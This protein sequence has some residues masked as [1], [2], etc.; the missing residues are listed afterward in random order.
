MK[1]VLAFPA[2][3]RHLADHSTGLLPLG[4]LSMASGLS[5]Q[6][7]EVTVVHL[8]QYR[9]KDAVRIIMDGAPD[10]VGLSCFTF[11]RHE[12]FRIAAA[13]RETGGGKKPFIVLG[14]PHASP[15]APELLV[16]VSAVDA[17]AVGEGERTVVELAERLQSGKSPAGLPGLVVRQ[18]EGIADGGPVPI[19][20]NLDDLP[21]VTKM[22]F[23]VL[24]VSIPYQLRHIMASRG[25]S[26]RC[27][28]CCAPEAWGRR[29]RRRSVESMMA[30]IAELRRL[31][32]CVFLS[33]RDDT[34]TADPDWIRELCRR[35]ID[36][37]GD[38]LWDCQTRVTAIDRETAD[39]MRL[40]G[41]VQV[42]MGVESGSDRILQMLR[43]PFS[44]GQALEAVSACREA[45]LLVSL[46][47]I[48]G[49]PE[50]SGEDI[51]RTG[52]FV[53]QARPSSLSIARLCLY[54]GAPLAAHIQP[55]WWFQQEDDD[56]HASCEP[57]AL[58]H[59][60]RLQELE[61]SV[62]ERRPFTTAEL[63]A[64]ARR[65]PG[66]ATALAVVRDLEE[67]GRHGEAEKACRELLEIRPGYLWGELELGELLLEQGRAGEAESHLRLAVEKAPCWP[68]PLDRLGWCLCL[69]GKEREGESLIAE[70]LRLDP[71]TPSPPP[72]GRLGTGRHNR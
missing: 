6:G 58:R 11:Q 54:P 19:I 26:A 38:V 60:Q 41:C 63:Q 5:L 27:V 30:E 9:R 65:L 2:E 70:A 22:S 57:S 66:P 1:I 18:G 56:L 31:Y 62:R 52:E 24:G 61:R 68:Y 64:V 69:Q 34:F 23:P 12:T 36:N 10:M 49:V 59:L 33:F 37:G 39:L 48:C 15:L 4:L 72:P 50:E 47:L 16:R 45:G 42:Q 40:A 46:Y 28:F 51:E 14:G 7:H 21:P 71:A 32:G 43:K 3:R 44:A 20:D 13:I 67:R 25:C 17:V 29:V 35:L 55:D 53:R 8:G